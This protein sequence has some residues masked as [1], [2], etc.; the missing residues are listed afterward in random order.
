MIGRRAFARGS[1]VWARAFNEQLPKR[2]AGCF[3][4]TQSF[5]DSLFAE[6]PI[7]GFAEQYRMIDVSGLLTSESTSEVS[8]EV[9]DSSATVAEIVSAISALNTLGILRNYMVLSSST[10]HPVVL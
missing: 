5:K 4:A 9:D 2:M 1:S 3:I 6:A 10:Q 8:D 7:H